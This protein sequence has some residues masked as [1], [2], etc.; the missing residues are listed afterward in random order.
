MK[1]LI[2]LALLGCGFLHAAEPE[3][4]N[5]SVDLFVLKK[6]EAVKLGKADAA[7]DFAAG[8]YRVLVYGLRAEPTKG[9]KKLEKLGISLDAIAGCVVSEGILGYADGY[10]AT[11][12]PLLKKKFGADVLR[13]A[14]LE[15]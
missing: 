12:S 5:P 10:N 14:G 9:E 1:A 4:R 3:S 2:L 7:K 11:M 13:E 6:R 15:E 8:K